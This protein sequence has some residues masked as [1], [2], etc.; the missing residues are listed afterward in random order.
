MYIHVEPRTDSVLKWI[1]YSNT[2]IL[3]F[4]DPFHRDNKKNIP[5]FG[6]IEKNLNLEGLDKLWTRFRRE[7][8]GSYDSFTRKIFEKRIFEISREQRCER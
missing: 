7:R 3:T 2:P 6:V 1:G 8:N 4:L 5:R